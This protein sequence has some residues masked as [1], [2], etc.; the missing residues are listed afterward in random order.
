VYVCLHGRVCVRECVCVCVRACASG[1][2]G[3]SGKA[4]R[5]Q[6]CLWRGAEFHVQDGGS[7]IGD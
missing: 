2:E 1:G 6:L 5:K 7:F 4:K 3:R